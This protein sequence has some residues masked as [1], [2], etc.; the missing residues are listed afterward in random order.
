MCLGLLAATTKGARAVTLDR[1]SAIVNDEIVLESEVRARAALHRDVSPAEARTQALTELIDAA[2]IAKAAN[3]RALSVLPGEIDRAVNEIRTQNKLDATAFEAALHAAGFDMP[4]Y[5]R[6]VGEQILRFRVLRQVFAAQGIPDD[7]A[8]DVRAR[9]EATWFKE[10]RDEAYLERLSYPLERAPATDNGARVVTEIVVSGEP[11]K[12][13]LPSTLHA[14]AKADP[15][16]IARAAR[17]V[18]ATGLVADLTF[19]LD[20]Q[21]VLLIVAKPLPVFHEL[22]V[23]GAPPTAASI[24][25]LGV[26][27]GSPINPPR[28]HAALRQWR[29]DQQRLGYYWIEVNE[30]LRPASQDAVDIVVALRQGPL[31]AVE[32][33]ITGN[34]LVERKVLTDALVY[35]PR[36]LLDPAFLEFQ[37]RALQTLYF[38]R[39]F[40]TAE[41]RGVLEP[42]PDRRRVTAAFVVTHEGAPH[43]LGAISFAGETLGSSAAMLRALGLGSGT[44][45]NRGGVLDGITRLQRS[46]ETAGRGYVAID[47][48]TQIEGTTIA[49]TLRSIAGLPPPRF[50]P[51]S[52]LGRAGGACHPAELATALV[53]WTNELF[54]STALATIRGTILRS[55]KIV[56]ETRDTAID[57]RAVEPRFLV[58]PR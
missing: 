54:S 31:A 36:E 43:T 3:A 30:I 51:V 15:A 27:P 47:F 18:W 19:E 21:G 56:A 34:Q 41:V 26:V 39:G 42:S 44:T 7:A 40:V 25:R 20:D 1:V 28:L 37:A 13:A 5:R 50:G 10:Q 45:F 38:D 6:T 8:P 2:L 22:L 9:A 48:H 29:R 16:L 24:R 53:P 58:A 4:T 46:F 17:S 57:A 12:L 35:E 11:I 49:L 55:C 33:R 23:N 14:G 32:V 52:V